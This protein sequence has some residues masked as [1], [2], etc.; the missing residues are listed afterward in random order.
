M[1]FVQDRNLNPNPLLHPG[2]ASR[3]LPPPSPA[4]PTQS[5]TRLGT[6]PPTLHGFRSLVGQ[7]GEKL[8][9]EEGGGLPDR[10]MTFVLDRNLN[11]NP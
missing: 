1:T 5:R 7:L 6:D 10:E 4:T 9:A 11:P 3:R 8:R 2:C